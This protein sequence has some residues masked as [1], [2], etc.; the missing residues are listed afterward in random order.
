[1]PSNPLCEELTLRDNNLPF[2]YIFFRVQERLS[3]D[4]LTAEQEEETKTALDEILIAQKQEQ[5]S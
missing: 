3:Q 2:W 4:E 5:S 1:M